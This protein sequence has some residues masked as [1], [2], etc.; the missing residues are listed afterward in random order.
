MGAR[1]RPPLLPLLLGLLAALLRPTAPA[2]SGKGLGPLPGEDHYITTV[3]PEVPQPTHTA[4]RECLVCDAAG[5]LTDRHAL[6]PGPGLRRRPRRRRRYQAGPELWVRCSNNAHRGTRRATHRLVVVRSMC[7]T[8]P[9]YRRRRRVCCVARSGSV[10]AKDAAGFPAL[11]R[12]VLG[13]HL[14]AVEF[15]LDQ[16]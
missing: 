4:T 12:A 11:C 9:A 10:S 8:Q 6:C 15:L 1:R 13:G 5:F 14:A 3:L 16:K 7:R 2:A